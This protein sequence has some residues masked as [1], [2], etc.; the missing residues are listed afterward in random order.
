VKDFHVPADAAS[1]AEF[2]VDFPFTNATAAPLVI[3]KFNCAC[4]GLRSEISG[5]K[6]SYAPGESGVLRS[7]FTVG[8]ANGTMSKSVV[9]WLQDDPEETP[10]ATFTARIHVPELVKIEPRT[11]CWDLG[12]PAQPQTLRIRIDHSSPIHLTKLT[13]TTENFRHTLRTLE[14]GKLYEIEAVPASLRRVPAQLRLES[15]DHQ[16]LRA[17]EVQ[18]RHRRA[19]GRRPSGQFHSIPAETLR[20]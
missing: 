14:P 3:R 13:Y 17:V 8:P 18:S 20:P 15:P 7:F 16:M 5:N 19:A 4:S 6:L 12:Q 2:S 11:L 9:L 1:T 10:S